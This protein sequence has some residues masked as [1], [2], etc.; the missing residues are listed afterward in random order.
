MKRLIALLMAFVMVFSLAACGGDTDDDRDREDEDDEDHSPGIIGGSEPTEG[1][2][3]TGVKIE[4]KFRTATVF[5]EGLAFV[6]LTDTDHSDTVYCINKEG[7][8]VFEVDQRLIRN[9]TY[10]SMSA[11][12][13][14]GLVLLDDAFCDTAG[15]FTYPEDVGAT[16]FCDI[17]LEDGYIIAER[18]ETTYDSSKKEMG[19]MNTD[20][21]WIVEPTEEIYNAF[22]GIKQIEKQE[23]SFPLDPSGSIVYYSDH[24]CL[25]GTTFLNLKTGEISDSISIPMPSDKWEPTQPFYRDGPCEYVDYIDNVVLELSYDNIISPK[26]FVDGKALIGFENEDTYF[27]ALIDEHGEMLF[28][29]VRTEYYPG[30]H[31]MYAFFDGNY[32]VL[33]DKDGGVFYCYD[34]TGKLLGSLDTYTIDPSR[35][36][37]ASIHDGVIMIR[38]ILRYADTAICYYYTPEFEPLF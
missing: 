31:R 25:S 35:S 24:L 34:S 10:N 14:N 21:E 28:A 36:F 26:P 7:Y 38:S 16:M 4:G 37:S 22:G 30:Y 18:V 29:P 3:H 6:Y 32:I 13:V 5:S 27:F 8:I 20:F 33:E 15:N 12:F 23:Y 17:A 11:M 1:I 2:K 19:V 9:D